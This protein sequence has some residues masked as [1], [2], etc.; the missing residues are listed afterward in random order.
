MTIST[1]ELPKQLETKLKLYQKYHFYK[2]YKIEFIDSPS[3]SQK[4]IGNLKEFQIENNKIFILGVSSFGKNTLF[5]ENKTLDTFLRQLKTQNYHLI[6]VRDEAHI[7]F[8]SVRGVN[9]K[10]MNEVNQ[11]LFNAA[12][13]VLTMT[14]T[15]PKGA[16]NMIMITDD[17][18]RNDDEWLLKSNMA[19]G[20]SWSCKRNWQRRSRR[21][22][23]NSF[24]NPKI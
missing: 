18:L 7:G 8:K 21:R 23:T 6:F 17:D 4:K 1:A 14:A 12:E 20:G 16:K 15:P 9:K 3:K 13:F 22:W 24:C 19:L 5:Y 10:L 11:R 2:N